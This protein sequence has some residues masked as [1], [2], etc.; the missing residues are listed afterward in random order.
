MKIEIKVPQ[1]GESV[2]EAMIS[3]WFKGDN[4]LVNKDEALLE[5]ETDKANMDLPAEQSGRLEILSPAGAV[6]TVGQVIGYIVTDAGAKAP[7]PTDLPAPK[8]AP[9]VEPIQKAMAPSV[10]RIVTE[11]QLDPAQI[12]GSGK[13]GRILKE[14]ALAAARSTQASAPATKEPAPAAKQAQSVQHQAK[15]VAIHPTE[16]G[17]TRERVVPMSMLRRRIAQRLVEAQQT[18]A[19]LTTFNEVDM[20]AIMTLRD[21]YKDAFQKKHGMKLGFMSFYVKACVEALKEVPEINALIDGNNIIY[22]DF[23]DVGVAV[24]S[25]KGLVVPIVRDADR[26]SFAEIEAKVA[27]FGDRARSG[28]IALEELS[29]GT[30]TISNGGIYGSLLS[31]PILNPPQSGI[32]GMHKIEKRPVVVDDQIVIRPMMYLALS[33]DHRIV[34]GKGAVTFLVKVKE[35][36]EDPTRLLL[37]I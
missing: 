1:A 15:V 29:G 7:A 24:G 37:E 27:D 4:E 13:A 6:V 19:I 16:H 33:Y 11:A 3:E 32:L 10:R 5:L 31:T 14:D 12:G 18:A 30:F 34:D 21:K 22:R 25:N 36:I 9:S 20:S 8:V 23:Y 35:Y 28:K 17:D 26:L 2:T